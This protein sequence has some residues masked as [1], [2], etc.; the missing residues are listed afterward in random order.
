MWPSAWLDDFTVSEFDLSKLL[1]GAVIDQARKHRRRN[2]SEMQRVESSEGAPHKT[3][4]AKVEAQGP[5]MATWEC[6]TLVAAWATGLTP[7]QACS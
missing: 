1:S 5:A 3:A 6:R 4:R 7:F 2:P